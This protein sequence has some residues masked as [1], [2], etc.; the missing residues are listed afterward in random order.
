L[1]S[2]RVVGG[3]VALVVAAAGVVALVLIFNARDDATVDDSDGPGIARVAGARP[4]VAP[5]NVVL[6]YSDERLTASLREVALHTGGPATPEL[7]RA[8]QAVIVQRQPGLRVP[9]VALTSDRRLDVQDPDDPRLEAFV[10]H[11]LGRR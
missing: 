8:G 1:T 10:D 5:G 7:I 3:L 2:R 9:V 6:L 11:W 4:V